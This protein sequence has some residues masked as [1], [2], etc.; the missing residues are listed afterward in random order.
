MPEDG[1][2]HLKVPVD[3]EA[4]MLLIRVGALIIEKTTPLDDLHWRE[5]LIGKVYC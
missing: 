3:G 1:N 2:I 5:E 4:L